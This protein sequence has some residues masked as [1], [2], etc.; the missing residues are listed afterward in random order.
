MYN[1]Y[2]FI[3]F[4]DSYFNLEIVYNNKLFTLFTLLNI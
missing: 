1:F 2:R 3:N 4:I